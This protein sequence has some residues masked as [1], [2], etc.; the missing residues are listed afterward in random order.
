MVFTGDICSKAWVAERVPGYEL[1]GHDDI[2]I[3]SV[4]SRKRCIEL[5]LTDKRL[6]C[7]S[8]DYWEFRK[9]CR[10]SRE[11]RRSQP[12]AFVQSLPEVDYIEN[13]CIR[14]PLGQFSKKNVDGIIRI[15]FICRASCR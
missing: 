15:N 10:L 6:P 7:R 11:D 1:M 5:C 3:R 12:G 14:K 9:E 2:I 4:I 8:A 13:T